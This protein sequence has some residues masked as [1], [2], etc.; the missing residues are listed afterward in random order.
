MLL[1]VEAG[2]MLSSFLVALFYN[3]NDIKTLLISSIITFSVGFVLRVPLLKSPVIT[4]DR[5]LGFL[6]VGLI[7]ALMTFFGSLPYYIG[8][9]LSFPDSFFETMSGFT[10]TGASVISDVESMPKGTL[11]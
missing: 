6:I 2:F 10:T 9:Y 7:W 11:F 3:G 4:I 5:R 8:G 1:M